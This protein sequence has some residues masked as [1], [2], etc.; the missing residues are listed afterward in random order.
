MSEIGILRRVGLSL[1]AFGL[2]GASVALTPDAAA[3]QKIDVTTENGVTVVRNPKVPVP[4]PGGPSKLILKE[5]LVLGRDPAGGADLFAELRSVGVDGRENIWT[6]DWEDIKVRV[7]DKAGKLIST[8]GKKGQGPA[9]WQNPSRMIRDAGRDGRHPRREQA[10]LLFAR[11]P[12]PEGALHGPGANVP[13][14]GRF[15]G[16]DLLGR[17]G[18]RHEA[19]DEALSSAMRT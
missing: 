4:Q 1:A 14:P 11:R 7:F 5:D 6:L 16:D 3:A 19:G 17:P 13:L 18:V 8:F 12:L 15:P 2:A 9:E 10:H